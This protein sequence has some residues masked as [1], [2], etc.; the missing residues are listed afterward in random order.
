MEPTASGGALP[1]AVSMKVLLEIKNLSVE[2]RTE[3]FRTKAL[4]GF[5][6]SLQPGK[7]IAVVGESGCGKSAHA[8]SILRLLPPS[9]AITS[10]EI[11]FKSNDVSWK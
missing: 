7:T 10:G 5:S 3:E 9:A 8:L 1:D 6:Y 2:F 4:N 11:I